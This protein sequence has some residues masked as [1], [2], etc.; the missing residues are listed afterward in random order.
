MAAKVGGDVLRLERQVCLTLAVASREVVSLYRPL[1]EPLG[2]THPQYLVMVALWEADGP[3]TLKQ[4]VG[5]LTLEAPTL[6][7]LLKRLENNG[8]VERQRD[9]AD[10]RSVVVR[11]TPQGDA[12]RER[13]AE[14]PPAIFARIGLSVPELRTLRDVLDSLIA[15]TAG[16]DPRVDGDAVS[17]AS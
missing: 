13:A 9:P 2:L 17:N 15:H 1:L 11:L 10:E 6:S 3:L 16:A 14:V 8:F 5:L 4:L 12:L 7:P